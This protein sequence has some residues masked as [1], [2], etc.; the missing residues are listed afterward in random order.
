MEAWSFTALTMLDLRML[1]QHDTL[2]VNALDEDYSILIAGRLRT[3]F[4]NTKKTL[5][6]FRPGSRR[7]GVHNISTMIE[8]RLNLETTPLASVQR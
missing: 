5:E 4:Y 8:V 1:K 7:S 6:V 2:S 3:L